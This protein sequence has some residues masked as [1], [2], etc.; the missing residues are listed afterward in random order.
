MRKL[1]SLIDYFVLISGPN[2]RMEKADCS[3]SDFEQEKT[4]NRGKKTEYKMSFA[5]SVTNF[6][7]DFSF[8]EHT[9]I[10]NHINVR[11][12]SLKTI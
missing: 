5:F 10:R 2:S 4:L 1:C 6:S 8:D 3:S 12:P 11:T 9:F 7:S